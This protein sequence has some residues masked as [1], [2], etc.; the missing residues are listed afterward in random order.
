MNGGG[1]LSVDY[2]QGGALEYFSNKNAR[3]PDA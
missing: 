3:N 1:I 2:V